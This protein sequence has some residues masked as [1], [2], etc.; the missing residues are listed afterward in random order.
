[1]YGRPPS[2]SSLIHTPYPLN[3]SYCNATAQTSPTYSSLFL[4]H[5][6]LYPYWDHFYRRDQHALIREHTVFSN[7]SRHTISFLLS[8]VDCFIICEKF[9]C[10]SVSLSLNAQLWT[11]HVGWSANST[12]SSRN[13]YL[14][15]PTRLP[16]FLQGTTFRTD[17][18]CDVSILI[19]SK[20]L[21][22]CVFVLL[23]HECSCT[24]IQ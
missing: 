4:L 2:P 15:K 5:S 24:H 10:V 19:M 9:L 7:C 23:L 13:I 11:Y 17:F 18:F 12:Y 8:S 3:E 14:Y 21:K 1:M 16:V 6:L 22:I 20:Y